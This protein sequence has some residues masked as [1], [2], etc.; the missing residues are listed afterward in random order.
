MEA[1]LLKHYG[2]GKAINIMSACILALGI[3]H[4]N[5][6]FSASYYIVLH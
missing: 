6:V 5:P 3:Q 1:R 4:A 2:C